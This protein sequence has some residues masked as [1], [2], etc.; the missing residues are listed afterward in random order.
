MGYS[1]SSWPSLQAS[2]MTCT[3][4]PHLQEGP[5]PADPQ[6]AADGRPAQPGRRHLAHGGGSRPPGQAGP[7]P[8]GR[9]Q[10]LIDGTWRVSGVVEEAARGF[11]A[12]LS[13]HLGAAVLGMRSC[14]AGT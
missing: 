1:V 5:Q 14:M 7:A 10:C 8:G 13:A 2:Q 4:H 11:F 6:P 12:K 9:R 3:A